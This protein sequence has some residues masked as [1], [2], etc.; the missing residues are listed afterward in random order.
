MTELDETMLDWLHNV[1]EVYNKNRNDEN[2]YSS[3][4]EFIQKEGSFFKSNELTSE[5][6]K[7]VKEAMGASKKTTI[8]QCYYNAQTLAMNDKT[9]TIKYFEGLVLKNN[10]PMPINHGFNS[11]NNKV[12]DVTSRRRDERI[13]GD[14]KDNIS[15]LGVEFDIKRAYERLRNG[16]NCTSFIENYAEGLPILKTKYKL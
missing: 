1:V 16:L 9:R 4:Y 14:L 2:Y 8:G 13:F 10:F 5:E 7:I 11:I 6:L 3:I 15:Y 12:I